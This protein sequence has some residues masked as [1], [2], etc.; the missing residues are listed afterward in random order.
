MKN[1][2]KDTKLADGNYYSTKSSQNISR[3]DF[4]TDLERQ[5]IILVVVFTLALL[6]LWDILIVLIKFIMGVLN[7]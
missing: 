4:T 3:Q 1:L 2:S 5:F 6:K 7:V